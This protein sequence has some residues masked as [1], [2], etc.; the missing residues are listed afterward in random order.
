L[1][2]LGWYRVTDANG[3]LSLAN[4]TR[5]ATN[6]TFVGP[7]LTALGIAASV[8]AG[9]SV[10]AIPLAWLV[11]RTDLPLQGAIRALVTASFVTR[12]FSVRSPGKS[13]QRQT[14]ASS[15]NGTARFSG[16]TPTNICST[17]IRPKVWYL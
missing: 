5:L 12:P 7:Y 17:S 3:A 1:G 16:S 2:W 4:F 13:S 11:A 6:P 9:A 8:A 14:V 15:T 10:S